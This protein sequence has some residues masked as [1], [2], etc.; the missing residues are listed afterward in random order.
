[1]WNTIQCTHQKVGAGDKQLFSY[2]AMTMDL[3]K[4]QLS[5]K[6]E[7]IRVLKIALQSEKN[8]AVEATDESYREMNKRLTENYA[9][10]QTENKQL[11]ESEK[12]WLAKVGH[13]TQ[14]SENIGLLQ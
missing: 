7:E 12:S 9:K 11:R 4:Q 3:S 13:S 10:L 14:S 1:M 6:E 8:K 2:E 5:S